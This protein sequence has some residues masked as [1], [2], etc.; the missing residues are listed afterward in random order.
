MDKIALTRKI[1]VYAVYVLF[2]SSIQVSFPQYMAFRGQTGD[3][4]FVFVVL[5]SYLFGFGDGAI[6]AVFMGLLRDFFAAP[7]VTGIAGE[8]TTSVGIGVF[9]LFMASVLGSS[10]FTRRMHRNVSFAFLSVLA[11]TLVYKV[12]GHLIIWIWTSLFSSRPYTLSMSNIILDSILPQLLVNLI[13]TV[14]CILILKFAGPYRKGINPA[15]ID[16]KGNE[17]SSWLTI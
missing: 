3:L 5:T 6:V 10:F 13:A 1:I 9:V 15:L 4:M 2:I 8:A 17:K 12:S 16:E 11:A 7:S 14:P